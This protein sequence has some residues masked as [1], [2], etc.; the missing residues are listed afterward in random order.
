MMRHKPALLG[1]SAALLFLVL[2]TGAFGA[3]WSLPT[4]DGGTV[5]F[6]ERL[7]QGPVVVSFWATWCK[8]CLKE[9]PHLE[10]L[11]EDF[12]GRV[13][14]LAVNTDG[15]KAVAKVAPFIA[16]S[17]Y[18]D[19]IVPLD[20]AAEVQELLQ[21]GGSIPF[22]IVFD[23]QG[24]VA[25]RHLGYKEGDE[26]ALREVIEALLDQPAAPGPT[27][28]SF[29]GRVTATDRFEY[30]YST[31]TRQEIFENWLD[32]D[33]ELDG[34]R[35]GI[36]L[37]SR[38]PSEEGQRSNEVAHR[39]VEFKRGEAVIRAGHFY[40]LFGRGLIFNAYEDRT[41]R[42]DTRL[43]GI[44]ATG[45]QGRWQATAFS[46]TPLDRPV[47][48]RGLDVGY[49]LDGGPFLAAS[50]LTFRPDDFTAEDGTVHREWATAVR[51]RQNFS[52]GDYYLEAGWKNRYE[53]EPEAGLYAEGA[54]RA[55]YGNLNLYHGPWAV[56]WEVM[57]YERFTVL[58]RA[59]GKTSLNRPPSLAR[60]LTWTLLNRAP[61]NLNA[62]DERGRN[63][64]LQYT[65]GDWS[66]QATGASL[67]NQA[68]VT[69]YDL[70]Y[71]GIQRDA[72]GP[73]AWQAGFAYQDNEGL[74]QTVVGELTWRAGP[75]TS[76]TIQAEHQHVRLGG[77]RG[78]DL[79]EHDQQWFKLELE[80]ARR[81]AVAAFLET[82]NKYADQR[83]L[84]E[85]ESPFPAGQISYTLDGGGNLNL[86]F[87][88]RQEGFICSGGVCKFEPAFSGIEMFGTF[89]Y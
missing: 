52:W 48:V 53:F 50:G 17:G 59:D 35:T 47:D 15:P 18:D 5:A 51:A 49:A 77:G 31:E 33:Y 46:G 56:S 79:G 28:S 82:N 26:H 8:P 75:S 74:R 44:I 2:G 25:Y 34:L 54:G 72:G 61:H 16:A 88:R 68:G 37:N 22:T 64:D 73:V 3:D 40:G 76:W 42:I 6:G 19:L 58:A 32:V 84:T 24:R 83:G 63:L 60:E 20:T 78:F 43:D 14:V 81:W 23:G 12:S 71:G 66:L 89:R 45:G 65:R 36:L 85:D 30:S 13:T 21:V 39:F 29:A 80:T 27:A 69:I 67:E 70:A 9:L 4:A 55:L 1:L 10:A 41:I 7:A 87:G 11:A 38:A 62:D 57:D 86:W